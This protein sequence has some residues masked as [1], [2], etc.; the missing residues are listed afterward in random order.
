[1]RV[2]SRIFLT[3][4]SAAGLVL[5]LFVFAAAKSRPGVTKEN[6]E[7]LRVGMTRDEVLDLLGCPPRFQAGEYTSYGGTLAGSD[8]YAISEV[9]VG[10]C[11]EI[12]VVFD[13]HF[14][15]LKSKCNQFGRRPGLVQRVL[16]SLGLR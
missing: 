8:W 11:D 14:T 12:F 15:L 16:E 3:L 5:C 10:R 2:R 7:Q 4:L 6:H 1:M 9:W 13:E